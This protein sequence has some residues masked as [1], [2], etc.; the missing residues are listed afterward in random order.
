MDIYPNHEYTKKG[1]V[2][3][4]GVVLEKPSITNDQ[5]VS[6]SEAARD[7]SKIRKRA[8]DVP[9][10]ILDRGKIDAVILG[11]DQ[12]ERMYMRLQELEAERTEFLVLQRSKE[13]RDNPAIAVPWRDIR[14]T[15]GE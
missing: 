7:F 6:A 15:T 10:Y 13:L 12:Y 3:K 5:I 1:A 2:L 8:K 9:L 11:Y 4:V 14:R